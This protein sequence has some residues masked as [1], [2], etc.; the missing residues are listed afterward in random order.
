MVGT[1]DP[2]RLADQA[3]RRE[4]SVTLESREEMIRAGHFFAAGLSEGRDALD[5]IG[6][7]AR[8]HRGRRA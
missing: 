2:V 4:V 7:F 1:A 3:S 8:R 5:R 6:V